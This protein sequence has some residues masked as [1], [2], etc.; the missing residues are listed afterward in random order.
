MPTLPRR[1]SLLAFVAAF[2]VSSGAVAQHVPATATH[3]SQIPGVVTP[4]TKFVIG[5]LGGDDRPLVR[6]PGANASASNETRVRTNTP[7]RPSASPLAPPPHICGVAAAAD[8]HMLDIDGGAT[9][10]AG[11]VPPAATATTRVVE[12]AVETD[13]EYFALFGDADAAA[14]YIVDL[15]GEISAIYLRDTNTRIELTFVRIWDSP[16]DLFN[17]PNPLSPFVNHW[18]KNMTDVPR[19]AAQLVSG[20]RDLPWGGVAYVGALCGDFAYSVV[21]YI[22]GFFPDPSQTSVW[23]YDIMVC[24]H[25][26]G[27]NLNALHTHNY[28]LD[29]CDQLD[30]TPQRGTIMSYCSQTVSGANS[31]TDLAF[32]TFISGLIQAYVAKTPCLHADCDGDGVDDATQIAGGLVA[33]ANLDGIPDT[34]QDCDG[35][36]VLDPVEIAGGEAIDLDGNGRP[37]SCDPDCNRNGAPD[38]Y[39]IAVGS[40]IDLWLDGVPDE[41]HQDCDGDGIADINEIQA[42]LSLDVNRNRVLDACEDC[43]GDGT[44]DLAALDGAW[45]CWVANYH[46]DG[47]VRR[48]N[49][50]TGVLADVSD[51]GAVAAANDLVITADRRVLVSSSADDRIV[52]FAANGSLVG[53]LVAA[54]SGGLDGP[55]G[56]LIRS[57]GTLLVASRGSNRVNRYDLATGAF[58]GTLVPPNAGGLFSPFGLTIGPDGNLYVACGDNRVRRYDATTGASLGSLVGQL[59]NGGLSDPRG[60][61]FLP[62]GRLIVASRATNSLLSYNGVTGQFLGKF[63]Q[64]GTTSALTFDQPWGLR[65][66][67]GGN[68]FAVRHDP[69]DPTGEA[70]GLFHDDA[71]E[72]GELHVN[73]SRIYEF[74]VPTGLFLRS[75]VTGHDT[76]LWSPTGFDFMPGEATDCNRNGVPDS[77]DIANGVLVDVDL[78]GLADG[79][80][81]EIVIVGDLDGDGDVDGGDLGILL[82]AWGA[83]PP[84]CPADLNS[85]GVVDGGD[86]GTLL[87]AWS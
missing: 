75:Y 27:H 72:I 41:C 16:E 20:R 68:L 67:P 33:D 59:N 43:D 5:R 40:S 6:E 22:L 31:V 79:C 78:D 84:V 18:N 46:D 86:L 39:D 11:P 63:N 8:E 2:A 54:G 30:N 34:C 48:M 26:L 64:G 17:E 62:D 77:C 83:C 50:I 82:G 23:H 49:A 9:A 76:G 74:E 52:E 57:D 47:A 38:A 35:N 56:L 87:G 13:Y 71:L 44:T 24:A 28:G 3:V 81:D 37:D 55:A 25:E 14:D 85:D 36:G 32:S 7:P 80:D 21:G 53:T 4:R 65:I 66:G 60:L 70:G 1:P 61:L 73:A 69:G 12:V 10:L 58:L 45:D 15:F 42:D 29:D 19:D 51:T